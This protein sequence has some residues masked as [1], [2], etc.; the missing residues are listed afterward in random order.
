MIDAEIKTTKY[1][2][3]ENSTSIFLRKELM[4]IIVPDNYGVT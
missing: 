1:T 3:N 2:I 4:M